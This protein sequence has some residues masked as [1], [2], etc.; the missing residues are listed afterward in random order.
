MRIRVLA[1]ALASRW[2]AAERRRNRP[3]TRAGSGSGGHRRTRR[4]RR[5]RVSLP[6]RS[7]QLGDFYVYAA[8][9]AWVNATYLNEDTDWLNAR[10]LAERTALSVRLASEAARFDAVAGLSFD[11]RRKLDILKQMT[12]LPAPSC[13]APPRSSGPSP[14][15]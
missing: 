14:R 1:L 8:K 2:P 9:V 13:R 11:T 4:G 6:R 10:A 15:A 5:G 12:V 3:R 7:G